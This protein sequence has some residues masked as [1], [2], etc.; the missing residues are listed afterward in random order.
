MLQMQLLLATSIQ[1]CW[2][3]GNA[4]AVSSR[5]P[6]PGATPPLGWSTWCTGGSCGQPRAS[7]DVHDVCTESEIKSIATEM[8]SNG[9]LAAGYEYI[10]LDDCWAATQRTPSGQLAADAR[11]F[12]SGNGTLAELAAWLHTRKFLLGA[13]TAAGNETCSTGGR[14]IPGEPNAR[15]VPGSCTG[16]TTDVCM[17]QYQRDANT[18]ASWSLDAVKLDWCRFNGTIA[19]QQNLTVAFGEALVRSK[20]PMFLSFHC[21][22]I[23]HPWC[24]T[25]SKSRAWRIYKDHWDQWD[26][27]PNAQGGHDTAAI[28][29]VLG[30][31]ANYSRP[32]AFADPDLLMTGGAGCDLRVPGLRC[33]GMTDE[34]YRTE[35][36]M[37]AVGSAPLVVSTDVRKMSSVAKEILLHDE[38]LAINQDPIARANGVI[39]AF[40]C[41][42]SAKPN[43]CQVWTKPL[44]G[45]GIAVALYNSANRSANFS[46]PIEM[47]G[48]G[49][50]V[51]VRDAW[52][53]RELGSFR[54]F[55]AIVQGH[56]ARIFVVSSSAWEAYA[57]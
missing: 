10:M 49:A 13:Y 5:S 55:S 31:A 51:H 47:L 34:E 23:W 1:L 37:W 46:M 26:D 21:G 53:R 39:H 3:A 45:Q 15:G 48:L 25:P 16:V 41:A 17:P 56:G 30:V 40:P 2:C 12:P 27:P 29:D 9:M 38:I 35:F 18:L 54:S 22:A 33:P 20:R 19:V 8:Q 6:R 50:T 42:D 28:I 57:G 11:R 4:A 43:A 24:A 14:S 7:G 36:I 44:T 52:A 32:Y